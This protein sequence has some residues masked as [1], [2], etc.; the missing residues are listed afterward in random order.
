MTQETVIA[1]VDIGSYTARLLIAEKTVSPPGFRTLYRKRAYI[2]LAEQF[3]GGERGEISEGAILRLLTALGEFDISCKRWNATEKHSVATGV[4]RRAENKEEVIQR[5]VKGWG[6]LIQ[7]ITGVEEARLTSLGVMQALAL[8]QTT[9]VIFDLGGGS[10]EFFLRKGTA[11]NILSIPMGSVIFSQQYMPSAPPG[12]E[13]V[14]HLVNNVDS[15]LYGALSPWDRS[16][17]EPWVL[18]GTGGTVVTLAAI[19]HGLDT[20]NIRSSLINGLKIERDKLS[21]L[22]EGLK[23]MTMEEREALKGLD[24]DRA[25]VILAGAV[26]VERILQYFQCPHLVASLSDLLEGIAIDRFRNSV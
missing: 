6:N 1:A 5:A 25:P 21:A 18:A 14:K 10:T 13:A 7:I 22:V 8:D 24:K 26:I 17:E 23:E 3:K 16:F 4:M 11:V 9:T 2:N 15:M 19:I 20:L 12:T